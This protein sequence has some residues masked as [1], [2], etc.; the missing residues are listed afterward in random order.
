MIL[1]IKN[2]VS[3]MEAGEKLCTDSDIWEI[4]QRSNQLRFRRIF[5]GR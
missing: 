4:W 3:K 2:P 1:Y 5:S